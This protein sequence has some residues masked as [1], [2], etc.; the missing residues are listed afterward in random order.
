MMQV[1]V[2]AINANAASIEILPDGNE[3][4]AKAPPVQIQALVASSKNNSIK[5]A[6]GAF[7]MGDWGAT[8]NSGGLPFDANLDSKPLHEVRL[9]DFSMESIQ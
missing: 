6:G 5:L 9:S 4:D 8:V 7:Q 1:S 3:R 2:Q